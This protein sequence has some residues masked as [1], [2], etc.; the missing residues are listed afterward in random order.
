MHKG[1]KKKVNQDTHMKIKTPREKKVAIFCF[2]IKQ[3]GEMGN[4]T[5]GTWFTGERIAH[6]STQLSRCQ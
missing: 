6:K 2:R 1:C 5:S 4:Q 3:L